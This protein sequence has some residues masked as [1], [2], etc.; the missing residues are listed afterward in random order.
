MRVVPR[1]ERGDQRDLDRRSRPLQLRGHLRRRPPAA[2]DG[3]RSDGELARGDWE[4]ALEAAARGLQGVARTAR[5]VG[6]LA[7]ALE[8]RSRSSICSQRLARGLGT[9]TSIIACGSAISA[10]RRPIRCMPG[11]GL[12]D[13]RGRVSSTRCWW[14]ARTCAASAAARAPRAQGGA[15][16]RAGRLPQ[17]GALRRTCSRCAAARSRSPAL[18][19][20]ARRRARRAQRS[21]ARRR[22]PHA[23]V[24]AAQRRGQ[25]CAPRARGGAARGRKRRA[26]LARRA[27]RSA[28]RLTRTCARWRRRWPRSTRRDARLPRRGRQCRRRASGRRAAAPRAGGAAAASA[29]LECRARCWQRPLQGLP[30]VRR[31]RARADCADA[32]ALRALA[33]ARVRASRSRRSPATS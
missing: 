13:R 19:G 6:V 27:R 4:T 1:A 2:A 5:R 32:E 23:G 12:R 10:T 21:P 24:A 9:P 28:I 22:R 7:H 26:V 29:G 17:P 25:R 33:A 20:R 3:A 18:V 11:L 30:A 14:S 31:H 16:R 15:A 8:P